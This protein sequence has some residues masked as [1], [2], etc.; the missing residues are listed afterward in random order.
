[1]PLRARWSVGFYGPRRRSVDNRAGTEQVVGVFTYGNRKGQ[2]GARIW[3][4][5]YS[6]EH[7]YGFLK[8]RKN[9]NGT[10]KSNVTTTSHEGDFVQSYYVK[11][12]TTLMPRPYEAP[13]RFTGPVTAKTIGICG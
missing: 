6:K 9:T 4:L 13:G 11:I 3:T 12:Q 2:R 10:R 5:R 7:A 1:M 8:C